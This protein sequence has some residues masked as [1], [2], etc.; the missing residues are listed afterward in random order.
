MRYNPPGSSRKHAS[1]P[2]KRQPEQPE[3]TSR[4]RTIPPPPPP[5]EAVVDTPKKVWSKPYI[6]R[7][8]DGTLSTQSASD[9]HPDPENCCYSPTS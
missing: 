3:E 7:I 2:T 4:D 1:N 5:E 8:E 9:T 6:L